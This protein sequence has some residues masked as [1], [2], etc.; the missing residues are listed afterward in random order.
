MSPCP[1]SASRGNSEQATKRADG[2]GAWGQ[3]AQTTTWIEHVAWSLREFHPF[4]A[5]LRG[6]QGMLVHPFA[7]G[8]LSKAEGRLPD[9][10]L[11]CP[12]S[13]T[14][15]LELS[16]RDWSQQLIYFLWGC[17]CLETSNVCI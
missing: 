10:C 12:G 1:F 6:L 3:P 7:I 17:S 16:H 11:L 14:G 5:A 8:G 13:S 2:L 9:P 4:R 15:F